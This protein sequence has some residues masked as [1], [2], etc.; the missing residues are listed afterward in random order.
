M[1]GLHNHPRACHVTWG[2]EDVVLIF[3]IFGRCQM[4]L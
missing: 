2:T 1:A 3:G 4:A